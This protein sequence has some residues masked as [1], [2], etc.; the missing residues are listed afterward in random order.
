MSEEV[1]DLF[2]FQKVQTV[3]GAN[4][5]SCLMVTEGSFTD[6]EV[7]GGES[8]HSSQSRVE[9][10][11]KW[12][13][14][15]EGFISKLQHSNSTHFC[16]SIILVKS[17]AISP[18]GSCYSKSPFLKVLLFTYITPTQTS[19]S[20]LNRTAISIETFRSRAAQR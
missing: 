7:T 10:K 2:L 16:L 3:S 14:I 8:D 20:P 15:F 5:V 4:P 12:A 17:N 18:I 1:G 9:I 13:Y 11:N 6:S 19:R